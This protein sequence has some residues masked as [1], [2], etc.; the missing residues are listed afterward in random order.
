[1]KKTYTEKGENYLI[2]RD[3]VVKAIEYKIIKNIEIQDTLS[4]KNSFSNIRKI[5]KYEYEILDTGEKRKYKLGVKRSIR[6]LDRSMKNLKRTLKN[7]FSGAK[8]ELFITLT[9]KRNVTDVKQLKKI[10]QGF[11]KK[12]KK[13]FNDAEFVAV[14][15]KHTSRNSWHIHMIVKA[16]K[17]TVLNIPNNFI[18]ELWG[19]GFTKTSRITNIK[20]DNELNEEDR[21]SF[22]DK[23][24]ETFGIDK[25][26]NYMCKSKTKE[27]MPSGERCYET[28]KGIKRPVITQVKY[29][30]IRARMGNRYK[31]KSAYTR[32][33][34]NSSTDA[35]VNKVKTEIWKENAEQ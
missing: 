4:K 30:E 5:S 17:H 34:R 21:I 13:K 2:K 35:I 23:I 20:K 33:V 1:M 28:S 9:T 10:F 6:G 16:S 25:V 31:L 3:N 27:E 22:K 32:L 14:F 8:N 12:F 26:I 7:N 18:E 15:E 24:A 11:W 19:Y 29:D